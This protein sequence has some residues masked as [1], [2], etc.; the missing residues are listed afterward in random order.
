MKGVVEA[1][2]TV[3]NAAPNDQTVETDSHWHD[4]KAESEPILEIQRLTLDDPIPF[5][6]RIVRLRSKPAPQGFSVVVQQPRVQLFNMTINNDALRVPVLNVGCS[7][8]PIEHRDRRI[9]P[10]VDPFSLNAVG[11]LRTITDGVHVGLEFFQFR[12]R[13]ARH[14]I[15]SVEREH[16][17]SLNASLAQSKLPLI[18]MTIKRTLNYTHLRK[19]RRDFQRLVIAKTINHD[20]VA[21]PRERRQS[22]PD[23]RRFVVRENQRRNLVEHRTS[24]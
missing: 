9:N 11:E 24:S 1:A 3:K 22:T 10:A 2:P 5:E 14:N 20:D 12:H 16:P 19:R 17:R 4:Y 8:A 23:V 15:I 18:A 21:C 7:V 6:F 13:F